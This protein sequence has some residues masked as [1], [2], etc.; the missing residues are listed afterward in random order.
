[1]RAARI[2]LVARRALDDRSTALVSLGWYSD[3]RE[4]AERLAR[5]YGYSLDTV[6]GVLAALSPMQE[7][8]TQE[9]YT[10]AILEIAAGGAGFKTWEEL[11][12]LIPGPGFHENKRKAAMILFGCPPLDSGNVKGALGGEKVKAFYSCLIGETSQ[13]CLDRHALAIAFGLADLPP[14]IKGK[15]YRETAAAY[16]SA[17]AALR[18]AFPSLSAEL[19][20]A[21]VQALTWV[22]WRE[23]PENRF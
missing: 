6:A 1:M 4:F 5:R 15:R 22:W 17:A 18:V 3:A 16:T 10:P 13:V 23:N 2:E 7:W 8:Q 20:P 11:A 12:K 19:T 14:T 9:K 21:G